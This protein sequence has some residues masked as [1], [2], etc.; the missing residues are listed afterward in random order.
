MNFPS[1]FN[2]ILGMDFFTRSGAI[3]DLAKM[4]IEFTYL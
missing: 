4:Q 2:G 3:I 1:V